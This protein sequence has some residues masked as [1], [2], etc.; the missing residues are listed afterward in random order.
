MDHSE[1]ATRQDKKEKKMDKRRVQLVDKSDETEAEKRASSG[2][3]Y[4]LVL[5]LFLSVVTAL[6][7]L[8]LDMSSTV[9][10][11]VSN[12]RVVLSAFS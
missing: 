8:F 2:D 1:A 9:A 11:T 4:P 10:G 5:L 7:T 12:I 3:P 6:W